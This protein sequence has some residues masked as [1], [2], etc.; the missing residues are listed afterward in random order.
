MNEEKKFNG[1]GDWL[2]DLNFPTLS[3]HSLGTRI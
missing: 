1:T 3:P 2:N